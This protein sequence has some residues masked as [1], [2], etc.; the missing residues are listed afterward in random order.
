LTVLRCLFWFDL[1]LINNLVF[2][3]LLTCGFSLRVLS[4]AMA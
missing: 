3:A 1:V 2:I 4:T